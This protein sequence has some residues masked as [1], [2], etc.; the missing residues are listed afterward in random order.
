MKLVKLRTRDLIDP[1]SEIH[2]AYHK[3]LATIT[4]P[5]NHDFFEIFLITK[6]EA[7]HRINDKVENIEEGDLVF[8][9]PDDIHNYE[10]SDDRN[11]ELINLAF[12]SSTILKLF[13]YFGEGFRSDQ[14]LK[15]EYPPKSKLSKIEKEILVSRFEKLNTLKR[16]NKKKIK[17]ELRILLADIF[18]RYFIYEENYVNEI[19]P[20]WLVKLKSEMEKKENFTAG[21]RKMYDLCERT[22]EH[23]SRSFKKYFNE[24]PTDYITNLRLNYAANLLSNSDED[25]ANIAMDCGFENLSHFYHLFRKKFDASPK[26]F[27]LK[28]QKTIIP[29]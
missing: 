9:R 27:R 4:T 29:F 20:N 8:I 15:A 26:E 21:I 22:P 3:S 14:L 11:C 5:H 2:Y 23:L 18:S 1:E 16:T 10:K 28:H 17:T 19:I 7:L 13:E 24:S 12:P 6:G 25:I